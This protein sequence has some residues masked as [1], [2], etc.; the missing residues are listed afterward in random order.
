MEGLHCEIKENPALRRGLH[1]M[2]HFT[3]FI[4]SST[5]YAF[6]SLP[7][8]PSEASRV[9]HKA[10]KANSSLS[11]KQG[12]Q[13]IFYLDYFSSPCLVQGGGLAPHPSGHN[14]VAVVGLPDK[15]KE[16]NTD[17]YSH[18]LFFVMDS[19][20]TTFYLP[21]GKVQKGSCNLQ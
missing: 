14:S 17:P 10:V 8:S 19:L 16:I 18:I 1:N 2:Y 6:L 5:F 9:L 15:L 13:I 4:W 3:C 20:R 7:F 12:C 21:E 11:R